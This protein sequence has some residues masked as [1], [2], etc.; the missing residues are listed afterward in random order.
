MRSLQLECAMSLQVSKSTTKLVV[1][2]IWLGSMLLSAPPLFGI[3]RFVY[4]V[5][6]LSSIYISTTRHVQGYLYSSSIDYLTRDDPA[7]TAYCWLLL[8]LA[9]GLPN[10][11]ILASHILIIAIY[12]SEQELMFVLTV[13]LS[14]IE[15]ITMMLTSAV[16][17]STHNMTTLHRTREL[18]MNT[19]SL[20]LHVP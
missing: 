10:I 19:V 4:E 12:R 6:T 14:C 13:V 20:Y 17:H 3:N 15:T 18:N 8:L 9:W 5:H 7:S 16:Q 11:L 1:M 2:C